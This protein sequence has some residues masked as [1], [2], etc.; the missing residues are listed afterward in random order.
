M[1]AAHA[2]VSRA[3]GE[4]L[5][6]GNWGRNI[7]I[8]LLLI[9]IAIMLLGFQPARHALGFALVLAV[10]IAIYAILASLAIAAIVLFWQYFVEV[11]LVMVVI[12]PVIALLEHQSLKSKRKP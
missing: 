8:I 3:A 4:T 11:A 12:G 2:I 9:V 1:M 5:P 10:I 6:P 7:M